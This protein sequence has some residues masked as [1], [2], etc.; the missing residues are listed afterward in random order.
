MED[1]IDNLGLGLVAM[2]KSGKLAGKAKGDGR[3]EIAQQ[4]IQA[5]TL[6]MH[7]KN[8][9]PNHNVEKIKPDLSNLVTV[10]QNVDGFIGQISGDVF[11]G[12]EPKAAMSL[13]NYMKGM[14]K[15]LVDMAG[16]SPQNKLA[17]NNVLGH[18][19]LEIK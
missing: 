13:A 9:F 12:V 4:K 11:K 8:I 18:Y 3:T 19:N 5:D 14:R 6:N 1:A 2:E 10:M 15:T 7:L 17:V 16:H